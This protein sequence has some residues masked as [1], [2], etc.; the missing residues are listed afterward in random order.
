MIVNNRYI[1]IDVDFSRNRFNQDVSKALDL[2]AIQQ[3]VMN[4]LLTSKN[5]KPFD[6]DF[7]VGLYDY[8]FENIYPEDVGNIAA[9]IERQF[10]KYE[11]RVS[12]DKVSIDQDNY[13]LDVGVDYYVSL[14]DSGQPPLQTI[15]LTLTK[16]R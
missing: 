13:T 14:G 4:L 6:S 12:F 9:E 1:D 15:K 2:N 10:L 11:P 5:E 8:L 3:S 7:G 16:V